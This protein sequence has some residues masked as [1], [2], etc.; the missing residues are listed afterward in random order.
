MTFDLTTAKKVIAHYSYLIGQEISDKFPGHKIHHIVIAPYDT[1]Q[2]TAFIGS[3]NQNE[4]N[5]AS[6]FASGFD[7]SKVKVVV[8]HHDKW[9]GDILHYDIDKFLT[10]RQI[11]KV[12]LNPDFS[13]S[14]HQ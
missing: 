12:Y 7:K 4:N 2:F 10:E 6:L 14:Q 9:R 1:N 11:E 3:F 8:I 5:E 13:A